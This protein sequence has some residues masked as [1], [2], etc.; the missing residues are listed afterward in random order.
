M[1]SPDIF[2]L[3]GVSG[4]VSTAGNANA[5]FLKK[6]GF[7]VSKIVFNDPLYYNLKASKLPGDGLTLGYVMGTW[8][9]VG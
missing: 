8:T 1:A 3:S 4:S 9:G 5:F 7:T 6:I 2:F